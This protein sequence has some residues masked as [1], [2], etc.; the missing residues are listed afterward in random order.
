M[1]LINFKVFFYFVNLTFNDIIKKKRVIFMP[2]KRINEFE[3]E[4]EALETAD[5]YA[6]RVLLDSNEENYE[7]LIMGKYMYLYPVIVEKD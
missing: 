6:E 2:S 1:T 7:G 3:T 5:Y 4:K